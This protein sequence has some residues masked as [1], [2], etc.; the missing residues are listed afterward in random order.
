VILDRNG[1]V[2]S[3]HL[4]FDAEATQPLDKTLAKEIDEI[5]EGKSVAVPRVK[6]DEASKTK[7]KSKD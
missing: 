7:D 1:I 6:A 4:G 5:L 2:K 3:V